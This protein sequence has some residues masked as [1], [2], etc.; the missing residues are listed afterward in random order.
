MNRT[1]KFIL[2]CSG[3][4]L[5]LLKRCPTEVNKYF[6]IG[7]S[8]LF[9]SIFAALSAGY[10]LSVV[11]DSTWAAIAFALLWGAMIFNLDRFIVSSMR[12]GR[13]PVKDSLIA[14][15]R[16]V[17]AIIIAL[18]VS[19][20][21]ELKIFE[22]ELNRKLDE[23]RTAEALGAKASIHRSFPEINELEQKIRIA[24]NEIQAKESFRDKLQQE[25]DAERFGKKTPASTGIAGIGNNARKK[26]IQL[27]EAQKDLDQTSIRNLTKINLYEQQLGQLFALKQLEFSKQKPAID[28]Y[29]GLAARIEA[30]SV[31][32]TESS[33]INLVN[34]FL[35]LLFILI[36][37]TPILIKLMAQRG[38]YDELM[39]GHEHNYKNHRLEH[40][41]K[42]DHRTSERL[43]SY[44]S[45]D[46][47]LQH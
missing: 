18:V 46:F 5:P 45:A 34:I 11:F 12:K 38:P 17:F 10:A 41:T 27:D 40:I 26:E 3:A 20:P 29:D 43:K 9:T 33:A 13:A 22:K 36:E 14:L 21:L 25:Y 16:I 31:L 8:V 23:K 44:R 4:S 2:F 6:G 30:L 32:T 37:T 24:K 19:K 39:E 28:R 15:P 35:V 42:S 47:S 7:A 1:G